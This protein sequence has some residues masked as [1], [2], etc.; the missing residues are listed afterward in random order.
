MG[1]LKLCPFFPAAAQS[2]R[3][4]LIRTSGTVTWEHLSSGQTSPEGLSGPREPQ[5]SEGS[6]LP[7][8]PAQLQ[9]GGPGGLCAPSAGSEAT[10]ASVHQAAPFTPDHFYPPLLVFGLQKPYH[11]KCGFRGSAFL[12]SSTWNFPLGT[13]ELPTNIKIKWFEGHSEKKEIRG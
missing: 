10:A 1:A 12:K 13:G 11:I 8:A 9:G 6:P 3:Q 7:Q 5:N 2:G 4:W